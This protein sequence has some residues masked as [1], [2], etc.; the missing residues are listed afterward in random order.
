MV[1]SIGVA[2]L[3]L[4]HWLGNLSTVPEPVAG[5]RAIRAIGDSRPTIVPAV[6]SNCSLGRIRRVQFSVERN[7][8]ETTQVGECAKAPVFLPGYVPPVYLSPWDTYKATFKELEA[9]AENEAGNA[10]KLVALRTKPIFMDRNAVD[11]KGEGKLLP[12]APVS[13]VER[14]GG[15]LKIHVDG[16]QQDGVSRLIYALPGKRIIT[17]ALGRLAGTRVEQHDTTFDPD[18]ELTWHRVKLAA[19]VTRDAL[20]SDGDKFW[21]YASELHSTTCSL[22]HPL[23]SPARFLA[24]NWTPNLKAMRPNI[25]LD[26]EEFQVLLKFLQF[27]ASDIHSNGASPP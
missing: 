3:L 2:A 5:S 19:W 18:T 24:N 1:F 11:A 14:D 23:P 13:V 20:V 17:A 10:E 16:W 12:G 15:L 22:C 21:T 26:N 7:S 6:C 4:G 27:N 25:P 8:D 9:L